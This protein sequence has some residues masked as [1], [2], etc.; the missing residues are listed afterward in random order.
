MKYAKKDGSGW[1][2]AE[3]ANGSA[4]AVAA[5]MA[6]LAAQDFKPV[7]EAQRPADTPY[8]IWSAKYGEDGDEVAES[9]W[10]A[11]L[12]IRLDRAKVLAAVAEAGLLDT[13]I[14]YFGDD[15]DA[16]NWW[17]NSMNYV[18]GSPMAQA[19]MSALGLS[20]EQVHA[21]VERCRAT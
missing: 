19:A 7:R 14:A 4:E 16:Q 11:P 1:R 15:A 8:L 20:L 13:A 21:L 17:A 5:Q 6:I 18:E 3:I 10:S 2:L 9:Y 12:V